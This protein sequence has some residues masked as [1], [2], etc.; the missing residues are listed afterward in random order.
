MSTTVKTPKTVQRTWHIVDLESITLGR[1][2]TQIARYLIGKH[3]ID[4]TPN[5]D[6]GDY[7]VVVNANNLKVTGQKWT[8][9]LYRHHSGIPGGFREFTLQEVFDQDPKRVVEK[10]VAGM[11]PKN[12]LRAPRLKRLKVF[13]DTN[14]PFSNHLNVSKDPLVT[15]SK[16]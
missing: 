4:Y 3:K 16:E 12:K 7:V 5:V 13:L 10:A 15:T 8:K 6:S 2:A 11:L 14:H 1:A 9:K